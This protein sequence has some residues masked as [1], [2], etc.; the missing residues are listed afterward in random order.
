MLSEI[1]SY[2]DDFVHCYLLQLLNVLFLEGKKIKYALTPIISWICFSKILFEV[3]DKFNSIIGSY[4]KETF[5][6]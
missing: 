5:S 4:R 2:S 3:S 6:I 1:S